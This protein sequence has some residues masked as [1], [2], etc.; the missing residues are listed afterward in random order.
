MADDKWECVS[1]QKGPAILRKTLL[2]WLL[3]RPAQLVR[4]NVTMMVKGRVQIAD[5]QVEFHPLPRRQRAA[6]GSD[7]G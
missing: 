4:L 7:E 6:R 5:V 3:F 2:D 1:I